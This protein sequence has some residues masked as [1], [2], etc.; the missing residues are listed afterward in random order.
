MMIAQKNHRFR[1]SSQ[2]FFCDLIEFG[3][4]PM[5][6]ND[7]Q[8]LKDQ[9][10]SLNAKLA[11]VTYHDVKAKPGA[12]EEIVRLVEFL[13]DLEFLHENGYLTLEQA[14]TKICDVYQNRELPLTRSF[15]H[16]GQI[17]NYHVLQ[18]YV[19][20]PVCRKFRMK[21]A[22]F[23]AHDNIRD[24]AGLALYWL[25]VDRKSIPGWNQACED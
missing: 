17:H 16:C 13:A 15:E 18:T 11:S 9:L 24:V 14:C 19:T 6:G 7:L 5:S 3:D 21:T 1:N 22:H 25:G 23:F 4:A 20:C 8:E 12:T 10:E 2:S